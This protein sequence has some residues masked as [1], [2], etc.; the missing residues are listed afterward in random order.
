MEGMLRSDF[1]IKKVFRTSCKL[2]ELCF[3]ILGTKLSAG[4]TSAMSVGLITFA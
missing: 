3:Y 4:L 1:E 2:F